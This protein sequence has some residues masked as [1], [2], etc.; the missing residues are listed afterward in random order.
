M[1]DNKRIGHCL[2]LLL[3]R[4]FTL[5]C[6]FSTLV[7]VILQF[8]TYHK[9]EDETQVQYKSFNARESDVY[10]STALC[11]YNAIDEESLKEYGENLTA[12][13]YSLFLIGEHWGK[14]MLNIDYERVFKKWDEHILMYGYSRKDVNSY[15]QIVTLYPLNDSQPSGLKIMPGFK[16]LSVFGSKCMTIDIWFEKDLALFHF[17]MFLKP[18]IFCTEGVPRL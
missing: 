17:R 9:G 15:G 3:N 10:P 6:V 18:D 11:L 1:N 8:M 14:S 4:C 12:M 16:E 13:D 7:A 5:F 2:V